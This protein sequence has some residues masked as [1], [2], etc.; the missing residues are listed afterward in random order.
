MT[1][2]NSPRPQIIDAAAILSWSA[3]TAVVVKLLSKVTQS[4][5]SFIGA[6]VCVVLAALLCSTTVKSTAAPHANPTLFQSLLAYRP[7]RFGCL[8]VALLGV[9]AFAVLGTFSLAKA[10][11]GAF[12][13]LEPGVL[14]ASKDA[15]ATTF[16]MSLSNVP[17]NDLVWLELAVP[18]TK[19]HNAETFQYFYTN[20]NSEPGS[21]ARWTANVIINNDDNHDK[22]F[23]LSLYSCPVNDTTVLAGNSTTGANNNVQA[24]R[25]C[26]WLNNICITKH[27]NGT[28]P[29][30]AFLKPSACDGRR[31][32]V[33]TNM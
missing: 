21:Q 7:A 25:Q 12:I 14:H 22:T 11:Y 6:A 9:C 24:T 13:A 3:L 20:V 32:L 30:G 2:S 18:V 10:P 33:P 1:S 27:G 17:Q 16:L 5:I 19:R 28:S 31:S 15:Q 29:G 26:D 4:E 23:I 8:V